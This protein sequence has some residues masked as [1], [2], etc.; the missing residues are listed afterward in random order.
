MSEHT[1]WNRI[2]DNIGYRGH[3]T[4]LEFNPEAGIP[5]VDYCIKGIEG[6]IELKYT[7][8]APARADTAVFKNGGLRDAQIIWIYQRVKHGGR[9]WILPQI[10]EEL[11][12]VPG[13]ECR[14]F[15]AMTLHQIRKASVWSARPPLTPVIWGDLTCYLRGISP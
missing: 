14:A 1:L 11:Y 7:S 13:S 4:R 12:L 5:D 3:F 6:K 8:T 2:R 9:A 10:G 15:N